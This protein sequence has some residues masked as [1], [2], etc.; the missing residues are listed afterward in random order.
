MTFREDAYFYGLSAARG[1]CG[2]VAY[3]LYGSA[4][5]DPVELGEE[6]FLVEVDTPRD[7]KCWYSHYCFAHVTE[8][9]RVIPYQGRID[10]I[11]AQL[12]VAALRSEENRMSLPC[13]HPE[14]AVAGRTTKYCTACDDIA[15]TACRAERAYCR[16]L[17]RLEIE[18]QHRLAMR[19]PSRADGVAAAIEALERVLGEMS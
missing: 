18:S 13:G 10:P 5:P 19:D 3:R 6:P 16:G 4:Y 1:E 15:S 17:I 11:R 8:S 7:R 9:G 12:V 2:E 14:S